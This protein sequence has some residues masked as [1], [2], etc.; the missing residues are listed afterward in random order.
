MIENPIPKS[1]EAAK[2]A[3]K[4]AGGALEAVREKVSNSDIDSEQF[5]AHGLAWVST[6][7]A[8]LEQMAGWAE[9]LDGAGNFGELEKL[10]LQSAFG[11]YLNQ[12]ASGIAMSQ[13]EIVRPQDMGLS[14]NGLDE[15]AAAEFRKIG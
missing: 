4:F 14:T 9:R 1:V 6:Y 2:Q 5:A 15:G 13:V 10:I 7:A 12:M 8:A 11:E 3:R